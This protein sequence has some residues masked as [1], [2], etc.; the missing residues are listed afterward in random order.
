VVTSLAELMAFGAAIEE[1]P[2]LAIWIF[3]ANGTVPAVPLPPS[4]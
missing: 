2:R 1:D 3:D 4:S